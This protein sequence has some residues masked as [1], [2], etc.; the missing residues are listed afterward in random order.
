M[1]KVNSQKTVRETRAPYEFVNESGATETAQI[2]VRYFSFTIKELKEWRAYIKEKVE[3]DPEN[4][5][6]LSEKL[7]PRI[8]SLPDLSDEQGNPLPVTVE[9]LEMLDLKNLRSI[10]KAIEEDLSPK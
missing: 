5:I 3:S 2:R 8:E 10:E 4:I 9:T 1:I 6:W 7:L